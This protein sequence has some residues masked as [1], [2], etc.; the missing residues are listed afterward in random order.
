MEGNAYLALSTGISFFEKA[1]HCF[2]FQVFCLGK[3]RK[4]GTEAFLLRKKV[5]RSYFEVV[6]LREKVGNITLKWF[7]S[8]KR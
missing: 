2:V 7:Y 6:L 8:A 3:N 1:S 4:G 5:G